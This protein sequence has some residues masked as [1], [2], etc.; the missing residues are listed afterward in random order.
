MGVHMSADFFVLK[1]KIYCSF[2]QDDKVGDRAYR[3]WG[4][5]NWSFFVTVINV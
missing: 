3:A 5:Q 2:L 4:S 1:Q